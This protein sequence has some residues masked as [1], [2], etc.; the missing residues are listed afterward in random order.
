[1][2]DYSDRELY[3]L[4]M[5]LVRIPSVSPSSERE[6]EIA[7]FIYDT[8]AELPY[9]RENPSDLRLLPLEEDSYG[10]HL[11]F[12]IVRAPRKTGDTVILAGHMDVV[13]TE[14]CG[15]LAPWAF[16]PEEYTKRIGSTDIS[17]EA[18]RDLETGEWLFGRGLSD[19]KSGVAAGLQMLMDAAR[20]PASLEAN[21]AALVVPDEE[22]NS[23]GMLSA[24][25]YLAR[26]QKEEGLRY[27]ACVDLEPTF[28]TGDEA[29]PSIY[30][31]SIGKINPFFFCAG[32]ETHVGEYYEGFCAAP[33][34][35]NIN[36]MLDGNPKYADS[37]FGKAYPPF[38][39]MRQMDLRREYSATIM[40]RAFA[41]YSYLTATKLPGQILS[42]LKDIAAEA[43]R[44][45]IDQYTAN[46]SV[47]SR[48]CGFAASPRTW[49]PTVLSFGDLSEKAKAALGDG[50]DK[51]IQET[52]ADVP[53]GAD[54]R[55]RA[56]ALVEAMVDLCA[57]PGPMAVVGFLPPW[58]PHRANLGANRGEKIVERV[59]SEA[60][61]E[62][63]ERFGESLEIR[64][65]FEGV[66]DLSYCGFQ[67]DSSEMDLFA[68]N[69]PGWGRPYRLPKEALAELDIPILNLGPLG[70]DAHK[71][72]ERIHLP[73]AM[74][75]YPELLRFVVRRIVE[76]SR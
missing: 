7:R 8:L 41:F 73:Y 53:E 76:E 43:L 44:R 56:A 30:L 13:G 6:N 18:R 21:L 32:K 24:S 49:T 54:E 31:G 72:T 68:E 3:R 9:F 23:S 1:M 57:I 20:D 42:D 46:A 2:K 34:I 75:V 4:L 63:K 58:Y 10:R 52:L 67:G 17:P 50:F 12:A 59:A 62:A 39:C 37:L 51:F 26:F 45:S 33:I 61:A 15:S 60:A 69:M 5:D 64:P 27:L 19:M 71:N 36:L 66:S 28:A 11:V 48:M 22:N 70:M 16:E 47:F 29:K 25:S 35:S 74:D 40:T 65:F 55:I 14:A 38:G